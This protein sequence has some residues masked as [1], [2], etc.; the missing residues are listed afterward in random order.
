[1]SG[2]E[3]AE[4][5]KQQGNAIFSKE[6]YGAAIEVFACSFSKLVIIFSHH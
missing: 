5:L 4:S 3:A 2:M 6:K 1:M